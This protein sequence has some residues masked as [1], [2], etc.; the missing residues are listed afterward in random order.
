M[1]YHYQLQSMEALYHKKV[2]SLEQKLAK[3]E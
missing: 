1:I 2:I 3:L